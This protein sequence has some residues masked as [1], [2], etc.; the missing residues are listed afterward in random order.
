MVNETPEMQFTR[1]QQAQQLDSDPNAI[2]ANTMREEKITNILS[3]INPDNLLVDIEHRIRG[4]KKNVYTGQWEPI[5]KDQEPISDKLVSR[6]ISY[7][8]C[9]LNQNTSMS[10]FSSNEINNLMGL[11]I[12][13]IKDDLVVNA[14]EYGIEG[15]YTEYDRIAHIICTSCFAVFKRALNGQESRRIFS[16]L[17]VHE[18][19]TPEKQKG[20]FLNNLKFW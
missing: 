4:E 17:K 12:D 18:N 5:V 3:Q 6:F 9:I 16:I 2:Y 11:T 10:N 1:E 8:G 13:W 14:E 15:K 19:L 7:L 20:G